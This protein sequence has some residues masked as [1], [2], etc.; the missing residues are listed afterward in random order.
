[1]AT[2]KFLLPFFLVLSFAKSSVSAQS[3]SEPRVWVIVNYVKESAKADYEKWMTDIFF[4]PMKTTTNP[5]LKN[6]YAATRWLKP[7]QQNENK[8]WTYIFLMNPVI[9]GGDYDIES[10]LVKTYG[11]EKGKAYRTQYDGFMASGSEFHA[12]K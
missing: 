11:V 7:S 10:H 9:E 4:A 3:A 6:Q 5:I 8:T 12:M 1:M 2:V